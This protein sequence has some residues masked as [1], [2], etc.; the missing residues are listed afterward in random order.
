M[1]EFTY[2]LECI[3]C[4]VETEV[5]VLDIDER[6]LHCPMCGSEVEDIV[7]LDED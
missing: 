6:P 2:A 1:D 7:L 5:T 4:E 3:I